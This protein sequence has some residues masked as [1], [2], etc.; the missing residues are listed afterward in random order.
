MKYLQWPGS[1]S[2]TSATL[3]PAFLVRGQCPMWSLTCWVWANNRLFREFQAAVPTDHECSCLWQ[4]GMIRVARQHVSNHHAAK[5][6]S[7]IQGHTR[8]ML[9]CQIEAAHFF[10]YDLWHS[11]Q[12]NCEA[13]TTWG[14]KCFYPIQVKRWKHSEAQRGKKQDSYYLFTNGLI[15]E[16]DSL[17]E[18]TPV[19]CLL[20]SVS[21]ICCL[22]PAGLT[23][24]LL[25]A[26]CLSDKLHHRTWREAQTFPSCQSSWW[27]VEGRGK[28]FA[29]LCEVCREWKSPLSQP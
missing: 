16:K 10:Q 5:S 2:T 3:S 12:V 8:K 18:I 9:L 24:Q 22:P 23:S 27:A 7:T 6:W 26:I 28:H 14:I 21:S 20:H 1:T 19:A 11:L 15:S 29:G 25:S 4:T 17:A 13:F